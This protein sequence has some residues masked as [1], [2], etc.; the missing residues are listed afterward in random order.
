MSQNLLCFVARRI[1]VHG[2]HGRRRGMQ[3]HRDYL[4]WAI[5]VN[6]GLRGVS[7]WLEARFDE[8]IERLRRSL[9]NDA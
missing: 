5:E 9:R 2:S 4:E 6:E 7:R 1:A 8:T 3:R